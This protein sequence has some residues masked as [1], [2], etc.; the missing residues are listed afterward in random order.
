MY[1]FRPFAFAAALAATLV[2]IFASAQ[3][4]STPIPTAPKPNLSSMQFM[5]GYLE[6]QHEEFAAPGSLHHHVNLFA[7]PDRLLDRGN[8]GRQT[9]F[10]D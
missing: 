2:P 5:I 1:A 6:L 8:F 9:G 3:V 10:L 4:E 7:R